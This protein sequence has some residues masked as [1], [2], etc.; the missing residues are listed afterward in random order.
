MSNSFIETTDSGMRFNTLIDSLGRIRNV[1][2]EIKTAVSKKSIFPDGLT[3]V[4]SVLSDFAGA[5]NAGR[6]IFNFFRDLKKN[7]N[8]KANAE[9][10]A[11]GISPEQTKNAKAY[12]S[13]VGKIADKIKQIKEYISN[14]KKCSN[15]IK[16]ST[17]EIGKNTKEGL[18]KGFKENEIINKITKFVEKM[19]KSFKD[20]LGIHSPSKVFERFGQYISEG[21]ALGIT[22]GGGD[23]VQ[24][25]K[26]MGDKCIDSMEDVGDAADG[27]N[28]KKISFGGV[29]SVVLTAA[30]A[31]V[32]LF[33]NLM[34]TNEGFREKVQEA[35][36]RVL[37]ALSPVTEALMA[38][39]EGFVNG[40]ET[41]GSAMDV[42]LEIV[43]GAAEFIC[44]IIEAV[45]GFWSEHGDGIMAKVQEIWQFIVPVIEGLMSLVRGVLGIVMGLFSED[46]EAMK[47]GCGQL[48]E[49]IKAIFSPV[50]AFFGEIFS[51]AWER[52]KEVFSGVGEFFK[53]IW[54]EIRSIF[55]F[56]GQSI[57]DG[58]SGAFR[59]TV[60]AV[61]GFAQSI[62]NGFIGRINSVIGTIN[63]LPGV[64]IGYINTI[65][66][67]R[68]A[69]GGLV[70]PGQLF[71]A[72]EAGPEIVGAFGRKSA[73]MNNDQIVSSVASGVY[74][75]SAEQN[76]ILMEQ[77]RL[78]RT[79]LERTCDVTLQV[80]ETQLG[81]VSVNAINS[82]A[83]TQG[84]VNLTI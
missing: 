53:N 63:R 48:W 7:N 57:A 65:S 71:I 54:D 42:I 11:I 23:A 32:A 30:G 72:G 66:I 21:L 69:S 79:L 74:R 12:A 33:R 56:I 83:R 8:N 59:A 34:E 22:E 26:D 60:N 16:E 18:L 47:E 64:H 78:L 25:V 81:R 1:L 45:S 67:P 44:G 50:I 77:N 82:L 19:L 13:L 15:G 4:L 80:N 58:V 29:F 6:S 38:L 84:K 2:D 76:R 10:P 14:I 68:L 70:E 39:F 62:I 61:T 35:W 24:S 3:E 75:A 41:T 27:L 31:L 52:I 73:V 40:T 20:I 49:G 9:T 51:G 46:T 5:F 43:S 37:E 36:G 28:R 55:M 17:Q